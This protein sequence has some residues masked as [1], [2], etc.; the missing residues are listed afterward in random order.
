MQSLDRQLRLCLEVIPRGRVD[1]ECV[2]YLFR[3]RPPT[4]RQDKRRFRSFGWPYAARVGADYCDCIVSNCLCCCIRSFHWVALRIFKPAL[5]FV[6]PLSDRDAA[7]SVGSLNVSFIEVRNLLSPVRRWPGEGIDDRDLD[8][9]VA[10]GTG[11][12]ARGVGAE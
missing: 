9:I 5:D 6:L 8:D 3:Q 11:R 2:R 10:L 7:S 1:Q 12:S 4:E